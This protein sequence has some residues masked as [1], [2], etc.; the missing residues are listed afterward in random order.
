VYLR[1]PSKALGDSYTPPLMGI[2]IGLAGL[3][4]SLGL[5]RIARVP[6]A[7]RALAI[8]LSA[9]AMTTAPLTW[10]AGTHDGLVLAA[11]APGLSFARSFAQGVGVLLALVAHVADQLRPAA[12]AQPR[13]RRFPT[14]RDSFLDAA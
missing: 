2:Q 5:L 8:V 1:F 10:R 11:L 13:Q 14:E 6:G 7:G 3:V 12:A 4:G 9:F